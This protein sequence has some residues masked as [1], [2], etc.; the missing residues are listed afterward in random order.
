VVF[1]LSVVAALVPI[2]AAVL[3]ARKGVEVAWAAIR[4][5]RR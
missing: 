3:L 4:S 2:L 5:E 1:W